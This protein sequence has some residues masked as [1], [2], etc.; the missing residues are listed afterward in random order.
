[1][2]A[3]FNSLLLRKVSKAKGQTACSLSS[4]LTVQVEFVFVA[5]FWILFLLAK[6][7]L[8]LFLCSVNSA[9]VPFSASVLG[10][11]GM[12]VILCDGSACFQRLKLWEMCKTFKCQNISRLTLNFLLVQISNGRF[13]LICKIIISHCLLHVNTDSFFF[14]E[15]ILPRPLF[16]KRYLTVHGKCDWPLKVRF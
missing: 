15:L 13:A 2:S 7:M 4:G 1:M 14:N 8:T 12:H 5:L 9:A 3:S 11:G 16:C 6:E 10:E